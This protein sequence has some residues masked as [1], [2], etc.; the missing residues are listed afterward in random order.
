MR[1]L[2]SLLLALLV[3]GLFALL[4]WPVHTQPTYWAVSPTAWALYV[5]LGLLLGIYVLLEFLVS[6][7]LL[8]RH[9]RHEAD[10]GED[11]A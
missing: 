10:S 5:V 8:S 7:R 9:A 4:S 1:Y 2:V 11:G 6:I 3:V